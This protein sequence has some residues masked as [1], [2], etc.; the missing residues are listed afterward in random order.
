MSKTTLMR[1]W[2]A[3]PFSARMIAVFAIVLLMAGAC[4][5]R[6]AFPEESDEPAE[7]AAEGTDSAAYDGQ[8]LAQVV[9][10]SIDYIVPPLDL[11]QPFIK[12]FGD[13]TVVDKVM[14]RKV[15]ETKQDKAGYYLV[16]MG[17][18]NGSYRAM[19]LQLD[20]SSDNS[21]YLSSQ[22]DKFICG[23]TAGCS[24]CYFTFSGSQIT[25]CECESRAPGNLCEQ[26]SSTTNQ[27][28]K[29]ARLR[30]MREGESRR[31]E[32]LKVSR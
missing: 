2:Q 30:N 17:I 19:A 10:D 28:L 15:Q 25:G 20:V 18:R 13:G 32:T 23:A 5:R 14:I 21:L 8:L 7:M 11:M 3:L 24:F 16:G 22:S 1:Q 27:L 26:K 6:E 4:T 29:N 31:L 9:F 12:E